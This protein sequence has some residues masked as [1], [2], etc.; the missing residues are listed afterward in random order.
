MS[1]V[2]HARK[3]LAYVKKLCESG[4]FPILT[5]IAFI[6]TS[7]YNRIEVKFSKNRIVWFYEKKN[8]DLHSRANTF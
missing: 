5:E 7:Y 8:K 6:P 4:G 3:I 2:I 1:V